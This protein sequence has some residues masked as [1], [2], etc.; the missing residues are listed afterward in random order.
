MTATQSETDTAKGPLRCGCCG[1]VRPPQRL[2][3]L[4]ETPGT[5]ICTRCAFWAVRRSAPLGLGVPPVNLRGLV[6]RFRRS[7]VRGDL[8]VAI[9]IL[10][11]ADLDRTADFYSALGLIVT[12]RFD[13]YLLLNSG[14]VELHFTDDPNHV[15]GP[16]SCFIHVTDAVKLW[17]RLRESGVPGV[18]TTKETSCGL[19]EFDITDPDGNRIRLGSPAR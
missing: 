19:V 9:P 4:C 12:G 10:P 13:G 17:K 8:R 6:D 15:S 11:S 14:P 3:E 18:G 16:S 2:T 5:F 1:H 7:P